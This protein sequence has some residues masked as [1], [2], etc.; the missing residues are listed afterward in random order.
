MRVPDCNKI[1]WRV[2]AAE[3]EPGRSGKGFPIAQRRYQRLHCTDLRRTT[4]WR[5]LP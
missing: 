4:V 5:V 2:I 3:T 1:A